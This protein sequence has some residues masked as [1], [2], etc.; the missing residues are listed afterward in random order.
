V[1]LCALA[2]I[3][4]LLLLGR[5]SEAAAARAWDET[6]GP[7]SAEVY[8]RV[9]ECVE[10]HTAMMELPYRSASREWSAGDALEAFRLLQLGTRSL[11]ASAPVL[12]NVIRGVAT[13]GRHASAL[14]PIPPLPKESFRT[15]EMRG[16]AVFHSWMHHLLVTMRERLVFRLAVLSGGARLVCRLLVSHT[17]AALDEP[18]R[19][20]WARMEALSADLGAVGR[21]ALGTLRVVLASLRGRLTLPAQPQPFRAR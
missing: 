3:L 4:V 11:D 13:L 5:H 19:A 10:A 16:M 1:G 18:S 7:E 6:L 20:R 8:E 21:E 2:G 9:R 14:G 15:A 17:E 12:L